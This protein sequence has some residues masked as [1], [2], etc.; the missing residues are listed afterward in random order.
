MLTWLPDILSRYCLAMSWPSRCSTWQEILCRIPAHGNSVMLV[1]CEQVWF[2]S[3]KRSVEVLVHGS[4]YLFYSAPKTLNRPSALYPRTWR[5]GQDQSC[6]LFRIDNR[7]QQ[8]E[9]QYSKAALYIRPMGILKGHTD[10]VVCNVLVLRRSVLYWHWHSGARGS[11]WLHVRHHPKISFQATTTWR[12]GSWKTLLFSKWRYPGRTKRQ[13]LLVS[14]WD[15][16]RW[17]YL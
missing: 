11:Y 3:V 10:I 15:A 2:L 8:Q 16:T 7:S 13:E 14:C 9:L 6:Q 4:E 5:Q 17:Q 1:F 12:F